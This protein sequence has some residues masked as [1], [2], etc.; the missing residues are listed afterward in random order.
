MTLEALERRPTAA[1]SEAD[2]LRSYARHLVARVEPCACGGAIAVEDDLD[3]SEIR[4]AV[5]V[6]NLS[7]LHEQWRRT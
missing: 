1:T 7:T 4:E 6:H 2:L 5:R 3:G